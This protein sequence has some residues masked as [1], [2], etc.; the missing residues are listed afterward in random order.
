MNMGENYRN[1]KSIMLLMAS[2]ENL[3]NFI[4]WLDGQLDAID[5]S[6]GA[7]DQVAIIREDPQY[8]LM[9]EEAETIRKLF[10]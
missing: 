9:I 7:E 1:L 6:M 8:K 10:S 4:D 2:A 5:D 3:A